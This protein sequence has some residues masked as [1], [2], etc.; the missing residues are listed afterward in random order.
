MDEAPPP[1]PDP[2]PPLP[3]GAMQ[4]NPQQ[5]LLILNEMGKMEGRQVKRMDRLEDKIDVTGKVVA[6][7]EVR[8]IRNEEEIDEV[9]AV[10]AVHEMRYNDFREALAANTGHAAG[11]KGW[12]NSRAIGIGAGAA[13]GGTVLY[14]L[15][16]YFGQWMG[17]L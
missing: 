8:S 17:W 15:V 6:A 9:Q 16:Y 10:A 5:T 4:T 7:N 2:R 3:P 14:L 1:A 13:S 11:V 12:V